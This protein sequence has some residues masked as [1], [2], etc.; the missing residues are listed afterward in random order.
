MRLITKYFRQILFA[1]FIIICHHHAIFSQDADSSSFKQQGIFFG[2]GLGPSQSQIVNTGTSSVFELI[3][4]KK[5]SYFASAEIGYFFSKFFGLSSGIGYNL[6]SS[7]LSLGTYQNNVNS[8]DSE[9]EVYELKVSGS[10]IKEQQKIGYL[11]IPLYLNLRLPFSKS[12]GFFLQPGINLSIPLSKTFS[13]TG[14]FTYKGYY[15]AY[16]VMLENLPEY[17]F[18]T[19][20][21]SP[22]HGKPELNPTSFNAVVS[23]G[24]DFFI[25]KKFQIAIAASYEKSLSG[26][27]DYS[28]P[29][30]FQLSNGIN[31]INSLMGGSSNTTVQ[32]VGVKIILR[33]Y[34]KKKKVERIQNLQVY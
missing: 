3:S 15:P 30:N 34:L 8:I 23:A 19:D 20:L 22:S 25:Q 27:S 24:L 9:N 7:Q 21:F 14:T 13:S 17:G 4:G 6:F 28:S 11:S 31:Q 1:T 10:D 18:S 33:Y 16:N 12:V 2:L 26:I 5:N 32:S 29:E